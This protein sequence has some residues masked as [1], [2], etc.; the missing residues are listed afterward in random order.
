MLRITKLAD[1]GILILSHMA[2]QPE[3]Q[4][5]AVEIADELNLPLPVVSKLLK[6][7]TPAG[8]LLSSRGAQGGYKLAKDPKA[9]SV[10]DILAAIEG[11]L[12]L[13]DCNEALGLCNKESACHVKKHWFKIQRLLHNSLSTLSLADLVKEDTTVLALDALAV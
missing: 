5:T 1:Y 12:A 2:N 10:A 4:K 7:L 13:T 11:K 9:I 8:F 6:Q 3:Q